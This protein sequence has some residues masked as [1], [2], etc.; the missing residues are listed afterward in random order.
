MTQ[1]DYGKGDLAAGA[2]AT[3]APPA[4]ECKVSIL[5][6][7]YNGEEWLEEAIRSV[8]AQSFTSWELIVV[9]NGSTDESFAIARNLASED[10]RIKP[11]SIP[12][13][14]KNLAYNYAYAMSTGALVSYF[15]ADDILTPDSLE[16]RVAAVGP[17]CRKVYSTCALRTVSSDPKYHGITVPR[18]V[19][20][21]NF[22][23]GVLMFSRDLADMVF[24]LPVDLPNEDT[25]TQLHLRAFGS[26]QHVPQVLYS[27]RIHQ[28]N[29]FG[30]QVPFR[31][32]REG[33]LRR[34]RAYEEF[35]ARYS[36]DSGNEFIQKHV[37]IFVTGLSALRS[38]RVLG[39]VLSA[40]VP[41]RM[42]LLFAY[43]SSPVLYRLRNLFF[44]VFSGRM[45]QV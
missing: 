15:A 1:N 20:K 33:F 4:A 38:G 5:L 45:V 7:V 8:C 37:A 41:F 42:R 30:Y 9:D 39:T 28:K 6:A 21:A 14:G 10:S 13:K 26:H 29:S 27:Y 2:G 18:D 16:R 19:T 22:S 12:E 43:Y 11:F 36:Q 24:P 17:V 23:G 31:V 25:W 3:Q 32:K 40:K 34:M 35:Y 44:R